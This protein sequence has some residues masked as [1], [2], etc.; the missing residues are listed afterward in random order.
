MKAVLIRLLENDKQTNGIFQIWEG[1]GL[2][3]TC[4]TMELPWR[5]NERQVSCIPMG[6][7]NCVPRTSPKYGDHY[8]LTDVPNRDL[9][10]IHAANYASDLLGCIG[11]GKKLIDINKDGQ[12]DI[13]D[14]RATIAEFLKVMKSKPFTLTII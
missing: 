2:L 8:H 7:Y 11:L 6:D 12:L 4:F 9:I 1:T 5:D 10:L 13:T 3:F 14:S